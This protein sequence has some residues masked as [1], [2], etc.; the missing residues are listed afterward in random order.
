MEEDEVML[1]VFRGDRIIN[2]TAAEFERLAETL[3][4]GRLVVA[5]MGCGQ[6]MTERPS[7]LR[8]QMRDMGEEIE[9][10]AGAVVRLEQ[11]LNLVEPAPAAP[12]EAKGGMMPDAEGINPLTTLP[13]Y[14]SA[15]RALRQRIQEATDRI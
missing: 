3:P 12:P 14:Q 2:I 5:E 9:M 10:L 4:P 6:A 1:R 13:H 8:E 11:A 7:T 15:V